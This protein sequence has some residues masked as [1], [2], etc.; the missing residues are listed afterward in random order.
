MPIREDDTPAILSRGL[1]G[2]GADARPRVEGLDGT[3]EESVQRFAGESGDVLGKGQ[4]FHP[5]ALVSGLA[6]TPSEASAARSMSGDAGT[7]DA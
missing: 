2:D 4:L 6:L 5:A 1:L 7:C 3:V